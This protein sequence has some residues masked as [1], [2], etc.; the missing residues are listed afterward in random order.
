MKKVVGIFLG[1]ILLVGI[2]TYWDK[3]YLLK[4]KAEV[5]KDSPTDPVIFAVKAIVEN[6]SELYYKTVYKKE[7]QGHSRGIDLDYANKEGNRRKILEMAHNEFKSNNITMDDFEISQ[8]EDYKSR[9]LV[10]VKLEYNESEKTESEFLEVPVIK[11]KDGKWY[12]RRHILNHNFTK[13]MLEYDEQNKTL[14]NNA[15]FMKNGVDYSFLDEA[16]SKH[17]A[18]LEDNIS[19]G[20]RENYI[21]SEEWVEGVGGYF[22]NMQMT[23]SYSGG[24]ENLGYEDEVQIVNGGV[25]QIKS[26][27]AKGSSVGV[28][29]I[30]ENEITSI[31][32]REIHDITGDFTNAL[33]NKNNIILK[34]PLEVGNTW[35]IGEKEKR[36]ITNLDVTIE[37]P[38]GRFN[39]IEVTNELEGVVI[40][41]KYLSPEIGFVKTIYYNNNGSE[42][43]SELISI[44]YN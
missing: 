32:S 40:S 28:Y 31:Y 11:A 10:L 8:P 23:L 12:L 36:T 26:Q 1:L 16:Y 19:L 3:I 37:T 39:T 7:F 27:D 5:L 24:F 38:V 30:N 25:I 21:E 6:N 13:S 43:V 20:A 34:A 17:E 4:Y 9:H 14:I 2:I 22:P 15:Y 42:N 29:R 35:A 33:P 41:R 44:Q 18:Q